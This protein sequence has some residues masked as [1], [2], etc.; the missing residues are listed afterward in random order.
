[1]SQLHEAQREMASFLRDPE[2]RGA[3]K[4]IEPRRLQIYR[5][6]VYRNIEGFI[7]SGFPVLRSLYADADWE[8]MVRTFILEHRCTTPLFLRISE[9]FLAFLSADAREGLR[10]F[11]VELAHYEWLE[12]AVDVA[13]GEVPEHLESPDIETARAT[14]SP[15]A[16]LASYQYPVHRIGPSFQ[17]EAPTEP[18]FLLVYR[19]R[20]SRVKFMELNAATA[21]LLHELMQNAES[22][23]VASVGTFFKR[24]ANDW[25][26]DEQALRSFAW[27]QLMEFH[28]LG[29]VGFDRVSA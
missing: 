26:M 4:G 17:P 10:G 12:L 7:S 22:S 6:L 18:S 23:D 14:L 29:I 16:Q 27:E 15:V 19:D 11:E 21:R 1:M 5:D 25:S 9:E 28:S 20:E 24:L 8:A 2:G 3:P 13:E